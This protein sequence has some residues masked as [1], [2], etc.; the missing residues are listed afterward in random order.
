[1]VAEE[2]ESYEGRRRQFYDE[3]YQKISTEGGVRFPEDVQKER[4]VEQSLIEGE[5][6]VQFF[7][8]FNPKDFF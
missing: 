7:G 8:K 2:F 1:L 5:K 6:R 3:L 4:T